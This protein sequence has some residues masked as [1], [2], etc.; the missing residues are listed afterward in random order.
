MIFMQLIGYLL[1]NSWWWCDQMESTSQIQNISIFKY[2]LEDVRI[3]SENAFNQLENICSNGY[4]DCLLR[5]QLRVELGS[6][7]EWLIPRRLGIFSPRQARLELGK[8]KIINYTTWWQTIT[9][10]GT[11]CRGLLNYWY[12][13]IPWHSVGHQRI[14]ACL[15]RAD[16]IFALFLPFQPDVCHYVI[17]LKLP[18]NHLIQQA[19]VL[20]SYFRA[21]HA[22]K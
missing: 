16:A 7:T 17:M 18:Y 10:R 5:V 8:L 20:S 11:C 3:V 1:D 15:R 6:K 2:L 12:W 9:G 21:A 22:T 13:M 19:A 4:K 14:C